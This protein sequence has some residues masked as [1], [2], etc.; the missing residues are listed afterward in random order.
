MNLQFLTSNGMNDLKVRR[1][2]GG[3]GVAGFIVFLA[4]LPSTS[5]ALVQLLH[6]RTPHNSAV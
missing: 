1:L 2:A 4:A 5:S 6:W 3:F